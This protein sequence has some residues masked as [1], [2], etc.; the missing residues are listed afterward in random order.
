M[1]LLHMNPLPARGTLWQQIKCLFK[2]HKPVVQMAE[3]FSRAYDFCP[4][5]GRVWL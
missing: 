4:I 2:K 1:M 5:C 3:D